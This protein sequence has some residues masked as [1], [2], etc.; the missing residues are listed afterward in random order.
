[1]DERPIY[2]LLIEPDE[3]EAQ[4][5]QA[6]L[7]GAPGAPLLVVPV[8][9]L[10]F[11]LAQQLAAGPIDAILLALAPPEAHGL[12]QLAAIYAQAPE[13]P[14]VALASV[15][16]EALAAAAAPAGA[17]HCLVKGQVDLA[18]IA[19]ALRSAISRRRVAADQEQSEQTEQQEREMRT[20]E[21]SVGRPRVT[22]TA[23][24]FGRAPLRDSVPQQFE[25][26]VL[27]YVEVLDLA[28]EQRQYKVE[29]N[30]SEQLR[31][32]SDLLGFLNAGPRDVVE[33]HGEALRRKIRAA[34]RPRAKAMIEE[35]RLMVLELMGY[36]V[37]FY[38]VYALDARRVGAA[39]AD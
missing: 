33:I 24:L 39:E 38:R 14:I 11:G 18:L 27:R 20:V 31:A 36:L 13:I 2:V 22:V 25:S 35:G 32:M 21:Q 6:A 29:H 1:M 30:V 12:A 9:G 4:L 15:D 8:A 23:Q 5:M 10:P 3:R 16:D 7:E 19:R 34:S 37:A 26:L 28:L 17:R